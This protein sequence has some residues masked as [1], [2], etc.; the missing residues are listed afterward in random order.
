MDR[1]G[2]LSAS[3]VLSAWAALTAH[4]PYRQ[5]EM[6]KKSRLIILSSQ[7]DDESTKAAQAIAQL[8]ATNLPTSKS[9]YA[10]A[11]DFT[12]IVKLLATRQH[13]MALLR[14][15]DAQEGYEGKGRFEEEGPTQLRALARIGKYILA[16]RD[17]FESSHAYL[18]VET[19]FQRWNTFPPG[20]VNYPQG[21]FFKELPPIPIHPG[22][23]EFFQDKYAG[24]GQE[25]KQPAAQ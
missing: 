13:D 8:L 21:P 15:D 7:T 14:D 20:I 22:A 24:G 17:D 1:R 2:F 19:L 10:R 9:T 6:Y 12:D 18:I 25:T 3:A 23:D 5:W 16:V 4:A 11:R